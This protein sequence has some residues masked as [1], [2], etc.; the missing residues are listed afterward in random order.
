[1]LQRQSKQIPE[2]LFKNN[3]KAMEMVPK[4]SFSGLT[5]GDTIYD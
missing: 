5:F 3:N 2:L 1:V 4:R